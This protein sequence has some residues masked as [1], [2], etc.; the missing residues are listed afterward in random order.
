[1]KFLDRNSL[2][3]PLLKLCNAVIS[4][5]VVHHCLYRDCEVPVHSGLSTEGGLIKTLIKLLTVNC[6]TFS[7]NTSQPSVVTPG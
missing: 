2:L 3:S 7:L 1:M 5:G 4:S 6:H